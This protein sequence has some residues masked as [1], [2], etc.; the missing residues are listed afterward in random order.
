MTKFII[1]VGPHKTGSS[2]LQWC[3][4]AFQDELLARGIYY[5]HEWD[6][7]EYAHYGL[8]LRLRNEEPLLAKDFDRLFARGDDS[9]LLSAEDLSG[10]AP[11]RLKDLRWLLRDAEVQIVFYCRRWSELLPSIWR[12]RVKQGGI[13]TFPEFLAWTLL[14][15]HRS[16][17]VNFGAL[18]NWVSEFGMEGLRLVSYNDV[19][20]RGEDLFVHFCRSFLDWPSP[21]LPSFGHI[22]TSMNIVDTELVRQLNAMRMAFGNTEKPYL[23][24]IDLKAQLGIEPIAAAMM[25]AV[26]IMDVDDNGPAF[27]GVHKALAD[28]FGRRLVPPH[29]DRLFKPIM[30]KVEY[31]SDRYLTEPGILDAISQVDRAL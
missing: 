10:L 7:T 18:L 3:F 12:E 24:F 25:R 2:Y 4:R 11:E 27:A 22:N 30:R 13:D 17:A 6:G 19:L 29:Q 9:V 5:P 21:P 15:L 1:H 28:Q 8:V 23:R 31:V 16:Q 14:N 20:D 26:R